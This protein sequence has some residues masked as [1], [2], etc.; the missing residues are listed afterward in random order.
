MRD[1]AI[2][3]A[4]ISGR[5]GRDKSPIRRELLCNR[6]TDGR[7]RGRPLGRPTYFDSAVMMGASAR[8][9]AK[10]SLE[11]TGR[12]SGFQGM[13]F[14]RIA[15]PIARRVGAVSGFELNNHATQ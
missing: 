7:W 13:V 6:T 8:R 5:L 4:V 11:P 14:H 10:A 3:V 12:C 1:D 9:K 2:P 15:R